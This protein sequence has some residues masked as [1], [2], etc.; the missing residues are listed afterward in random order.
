[1]IKDTQ[2][3]IATIRLK[4]IGDW[5]VKKPQPKTVTENIRAI[6]LFFRNCASS[7]FV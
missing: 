4:K 3:S 7:I 1:M 6:S 2:S 5:E